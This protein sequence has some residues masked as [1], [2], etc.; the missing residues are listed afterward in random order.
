MFKSLLIVLVLAVAFPAVAQKAKHDFSKLDPAWAANEIDSSFQ[1]GEAKAAWQALKR[2]FPDD[3]RAFIAEYANA[4]IKGDEL[5]PISGRFFQGHTVGALDLARKA[6]AAQLAR[7][8]HQRARLIEQLATSNIQACAAMARGSA[9]TPPSDP[10]GLAILY[11]N[12]AAFADAAGAGRDSPTQHA[13]VDARDLES[14]KA[15]IVAQGGSRQE[16]DA[17]FSPAAYAADDTNACRYGLM[18]FRAT[19]IAPDETAGKFAIR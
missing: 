2:N 13:T 15:L 19:A 6:P 9:P 12:L 16:A 1:G 17:V 10:V 5:A 8:Q 11:D 3:Y 4:M 14:L 18:L 7:V